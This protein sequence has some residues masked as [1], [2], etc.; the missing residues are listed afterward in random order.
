MKKYLSHFTG[1]IVPPAIIT[2][3]ASARMSAKCTA[4]FS[5]KNLSDEFLSVSADQTATCQSAFVTKAITVVAFLV[6]CY[7]QQQK[8]KAITAEI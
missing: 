5:S 4:G 1:C 2:A 6:R 3:L 8:F 7:T